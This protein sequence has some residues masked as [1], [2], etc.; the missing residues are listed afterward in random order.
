MVSTLTWV[1]AG[2]VLYTLVVMVLRTR[3]V[4]PEFIRVQGPIT[5]VHTKR[6]RAFLDWLATPKRF[7]R[8][9]GNFGVGI[10]LVVMFGSFL[11]VLFAALQ[12]VSQPE[13]TAVQNPQNVLVIPGVNEFLPL[14]AAPEIVFGLLLGLVVHEGGHGL[15]CRVEDID[16]ESMG[17]ALFTIIPVG[18]FVEP[19]EESRERANRGSQT[20]M[21]AAGVTNNFAITLV[22]FLLLFGPIIG[23]IAVVSGVPVGDVAQGSAAA[24]AGIERGTVMTGV[25]GT[26]VANESELDDVLRENGARTVEVQRQDAPPIRVNRSLMITRAI[27][28]VLDGRTPEEGVDLS[29][30][31]PPTILAVND[32]RVYT[33]QD[34]AAALEDRTVVTLATTDGNATFPVGAYAS[35]LT[36]DGPLDSAG[37]PTEGPLVLTRVGGERVTDTDSLR[38]VLSDYAPGDTVRVEAYVGDDFR[39]EVYEVELGENP[40]GSGGAYLGIFL[41]QGLSGVTVD[42][43]GIDVY[44][45]ESFL[46]LLGG[47]DGSLGGLSPDSIVQQ[48]F[49][50]LLMPF[51]SVLEPQFAYN[52]AGF[53][54]SVADFYTTTGPLGFLGGGVLML[55]NVAFWTGWINLQLGLFN[56]IPAFP[57]DGG[58]ILRTSTEAAVSR[59][60]VEGGRRLTTAITVSITLVMLAGL[61]LMVFGPG[62]LTS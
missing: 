58:H 40:D 55:A 13:A 8:A 56:C 30:E 28:G 43:F 61:F 18:A 24:A 32:T 11:M 20:R 26:P 41:Q 54:P 5:T 33:Q 2:I 48:V 49:A 47:G 44:P 10:A 59:L 42:D 29:G 16:I 50:V 4:L 25:D 38:T 6:G 34:L 7:W 60:P 36:E 21:F 14:S 57:L 19:S 53:V 3:G 23:S 39:R 1:L 35:Q 27:P 62:L 52:F 17:L 15:L 9:W 51:L 12:S 46:A 31:A 22:A 45:A 37:A